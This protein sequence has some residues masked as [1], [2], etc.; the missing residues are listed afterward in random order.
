MENRELAYDISK[1]PLGESI[2]FGVVSLG[3]MLNF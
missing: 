2:S 3:D 1:G